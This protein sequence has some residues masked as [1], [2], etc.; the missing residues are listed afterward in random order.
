MATL[1]EVRC[2][3]QRERSF[4]GRPRPVRSGIA[5]ARVQ[6]VAHR[7][8]VLLDDQ[9]QC[10]GITT[11]IIAFITGRMLVMLVRVRITCHSSLTQLAQVFGACTVSGD[12]DYKC[13]I[14]RYTEP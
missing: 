4:V 8:E 5:L 3:K 14:R 10:I 13:R 9:V 7:S 11:I 6:P 1:A 12:G 2:N